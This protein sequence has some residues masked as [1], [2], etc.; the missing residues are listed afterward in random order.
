MGSGVSSFEVTA[1]PVELPNG[2][3]KVNM[4]MGENALSREEEAYLQGRSEE[5]GRKNAQMLKYV[6]KF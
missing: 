5:G 3:I 1:N 6:E 4:V 2:E